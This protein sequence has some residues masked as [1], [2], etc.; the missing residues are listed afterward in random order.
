MKKIRKCS[1]ENSKEKTA[2]DLSD[3]LKLQKERNFTLRTIWR[4][5][6]HHQYKQIVA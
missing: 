3:V 6:K 1:Y 2:F 4:R 5:D